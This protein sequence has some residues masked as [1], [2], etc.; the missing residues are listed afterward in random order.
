[1]SI[2][3]GCSIESVAP[4]MEKACHE[5]VKRNDLDFF[6][7]V[8]DVLR[9]RQNTV[10][11]YLVPVPKLRFF[12][13][14]HWV[15]EINGVPPLYSLSISKLLEVCKKH[16]DVGGLTFDSVEK[17]RQRIGLLTF[18]SHD[19]SSKGKGA[20]R[21]KRERLPSQYQM[22]PVTFDKSGGINLGPNWSFLRPDSK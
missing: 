9:K 7:K 2:K 13:M 17:T 21:R 5:A 1:M 20:G 6:K 15:K 14:A 19:Q 22:V 10:E 11:D 12:L 4:F 18:R 8:G 3:N 16:L